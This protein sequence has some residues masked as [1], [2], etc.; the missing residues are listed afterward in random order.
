[1][2]LSLMLILTGCGATKSNKA[3]EEQKMK[4]YKLKRE[5]VRLLTI[6]VVKLKCQISL[7][8]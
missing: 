8:E 5:L 3:Q 1:M 2:V 4:T 7:N 6:S